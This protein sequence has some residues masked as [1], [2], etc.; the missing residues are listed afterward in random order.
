MT[1]EEIVTKIDNGDYNTQIPPP[2]Y[3][4]G[5]VN[6]DEDEMWRLD[7]ERL[8]QMFEDDCRSYT[9][10]RLEQTITSDQFQSLFRYVWEEGHSSGYSEVLIVLDNMLDVIEE[11]IE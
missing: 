2:T 7:K 4:D 9:E 10:T 11:F 5:K 8:R 3:T 6:K 1:Y